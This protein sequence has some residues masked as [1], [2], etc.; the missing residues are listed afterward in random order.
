MSLVSKYIVNSDVSITDDGGTASVNLGTDP[1]R[2]VLCVSTCWTTNTGMP[3]GAF[4][5]I[6]GTQMSCLVNNYYSWGYGAGQTSFFLCY[7]SNPPEGVQTLTG[8]NET[9]GSPTHINIFVILRVSI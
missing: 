9:Y 6:A 5:K 8:Y 7:N 3:F 2:L 1:N 4:P